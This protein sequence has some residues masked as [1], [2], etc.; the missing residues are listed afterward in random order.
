MAKKIRP[1]YI[2]RHEGYKGF[3]VIQCPECGKIRA[4][5]TKNEIIWYRCKRCREVFPLEAMR[6]VY[7]NGCPCCGTR[8]RY[9]TN[10]VGESFDIKCINCK[11]P[12][13]LLWNE[14]HKAFVSITE[15]E[16]RRAT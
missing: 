2:I 14:K 5:M 11:A 9:L 15:Q 3:L 7:V 4:F 13:D 6:R 10:A 16:R 8:L 12:V 1:E